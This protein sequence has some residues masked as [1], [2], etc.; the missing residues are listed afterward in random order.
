M[1]NA[2]SRLSGMLLWE[3][4][5]AFL[6]FLMALDRLA[7]IHF[8]KS[9]LSPWIYAG[10]GMIFSAIC[11]ACLFLILQPKKPVSI[12]LATAATIPTFVG[13]YAAS[14]FFFPYFF[15]MVIAKTWFIV[16]FPLFVSMSLFVEACFRTRGLRERLRKPPLID[17]MS[18]AP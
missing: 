3:Y 2:T 18:S 11:C 1:N 16:G 9:G 6:T 13:V 5:I 10:G 12:F 17:K 15:P 8:P 14:V 4:G 7:A